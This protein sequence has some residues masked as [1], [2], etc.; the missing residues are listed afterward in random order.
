MSIIRRAWAAI[1]Q[2][3]MLKTFSKNSAVQAGE[4]LV[5]VIVGL[6]VTVYLARELGP[7]LFGV[8][9]LC[10]A[11]LRIAMTSLA[12]GLDVLIIRHSSGDERPDESY[13]SSVL[14]LR[15]INSLT[16]LAA[17][18]LGIY[19]LGGINAQTANLVL[20]MM[21]ALLVVPFDGLEFWFRATKDAVTP[22]I[23]RSVSVILGSALKVALIASGA[24]L[25][26]VG[27]AHA[28]QMALFGLIL[29]GFYL[30][31]GFGFTFDKD[32][33]PRVK[34]LYREGWPLFVTT[35]GYLV[36]ARIDIVMLSWIKGDHAA[37]EYAAAVRISEVASLAPVVLMTA[38]SPFVFNGMRN[39]VKK[40]STLF[41][42]LL[43]AFNIFFFAIAA[44]VCLLAPLVVHI[45]FGPTY[46]AAAAILS[47]HIFGLIFVAQGV[48]TQYWWVAR[49]R[50]NILM[51][52]AIAGGVVNIALNLALIPLYGGIGAAIAT[53]ASQFFASVGINVFLG[54]HG[55]H[56]MRLQL[57]PNLR[58]SK[59][60]DIDG[61]VGQSS[62]VTRRPAAPTA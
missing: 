52:R 55:W 32:V 40:F 49:R 34:S 39:N 61:L 3:S 19:L 53:V 25:V 51:W 14:V 9:S 38:A 57:V 33:M 12:F 11:L 31:R 15:T 35:L 28:L 29:L 10:I 37:G 7:A 6:A 2:S 5:N 24:A 17:G 4:Q 30:W 21:P 26:F 18:L 16:I 56:L 59:N 20:V 46:S 58:L 47:V 60:L 13:L 27:A 42:V 43:T 48:A 22:A 45:L 50:Q 62:R 44:V 36:Y 1:A 23:A 8:W 54:R 41:H